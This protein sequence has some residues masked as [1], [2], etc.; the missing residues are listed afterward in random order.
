MAGR[1]QIHVGLRDRS[2]LSTDRPFE[3]QTDPSLMIGGSTRLLHLN[4]SLLHPPFQGSQ[5][6][7]FPTL[8]NQ[9]GSVGKERPTVFGPFSPWVPPPF[10]ETNK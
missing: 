7:P 4:I 1:I 2:V 8:W 3:Y 10:F 6:F 5:V 9:Q